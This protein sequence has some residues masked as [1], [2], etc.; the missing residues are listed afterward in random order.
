MFLSMGVIGTGRVGTAL[1]LLARERGLSVAG[2]WNR[3]AAKGEEAARLV[4]SPLFQELGDLLGRCNWLWLTVAD[5]ALPELVTRLVDYS[6]QDKTVVHTSGALS[7]EVLVPLREKGA[8]ILSFHPLQTIADWQQARHNLPGSLVA[9]EG[10]EDAVQVG[11]KL[12]QRLGLRPFAIAREAKALYHGAAVVAS[13]YL[14]TLAYWAEKWMET[15]G[16]PA[17]AA[18]QGLV[19]LMQGALNNL[20]SLGPVAALTGPLVRGDVLTVKSHLQVTAEQGIAELEQKLYR[21]LGLLTMEIARQR[22]LA[23]EVEAELLGILKGE[24]ACG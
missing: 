7:S 14:V 22:G 3:T 2:L 12:A 5:Y 8:N 9:L 10:D 1:A 4:Q 19:A 20:S 6:W 21:Q 16:I 15:A 17:A 18:N 24:I 13:N 23:P 11:L